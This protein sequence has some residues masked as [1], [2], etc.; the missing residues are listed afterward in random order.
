MK[1]ISFLLLFAVGAITAQTREK[2][3]VIKSN[4]LAYTLRNVNAGYEHIFTRRFSLGASVGFMMKGAIP[5]VNTFNNDENLK[6]DKATVSGQTYTVEPRFYLGK[7]YGEGLYLSPYLRFSSFIVNRVVYYYHG[8]S[9]NVSYTVPITFGGKVNGTSGGL[10]FG[11]QWFLG[12]KKNWV[13]DAWFIGAHYGSGNGDIIG[14]SPVPL[15][16][17]MQQDIKR[18]IDNTDIPLIKLDATMN[19]RGADAKVGGPWAGLRTGL[20][21]GYRF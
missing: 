3:N 18:E 10:L 1:K 19:E 11:G 4:V 2:P 15:S 16:V 12:E 8:T 13:L 6:T 21:V 9:D 20:S 7:G 17:K 5:F 14:R